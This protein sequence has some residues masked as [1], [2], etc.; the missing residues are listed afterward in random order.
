MAPADVPRA[1]EGGASMREVNQQQDTGQGRAIELGAAAGFPIVVQI[2][3][4]RGPIS[5]IAASP[6]GTRLMV[7]TYGGAPEGGGQPAGGTGSRLPHRTRA[8]SGPPSRAG[9]SRSR[10]PGAAA[11]PTGH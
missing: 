9:G 11:T 1:S 6:D 3:V 4:R 10:S 5:G 8:A 2:A 7:A